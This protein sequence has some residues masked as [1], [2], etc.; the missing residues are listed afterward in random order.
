[1]G[2]F[3]W[4]FGRKRH[5]AQN[6]GGEP[7]GRHAAVPAGP[8]VA[9]MR[10]PVPQPQGRHAGRSGD[11]AFDVFL[12]NAQVAD[13]I[14]V[15]VE[16]IGGGEQLEIIEFGALLLRG[17]EVIHR[18]DV[19]I[20]P[21]AML[22]ASATLLTGITPEQLADAPD[23]G[24]VLPGIAEA[25]NGLAV[26]GHNVGYDVNALGLSCSRYGI[27][28]HVGALFDTLEMSR[29]LFPNA[30]SHTL[31]E[32]MR[33]VGI[34]RIEQHRAINDAEDTFECWMRMRAMDG[35]RYLSLGER[36]IHEEKSKA[37][38]TRKNAVFIKGMYLDDHDITPVNEKPDAA[39]EIVCLEEGVEINGEED[40]Q[41]LIGSYGY[42]AWL[43]VFVTENLIRKGKNEGYPTYWVY[44]D[45]VE[46]GHISKYQ[47]ERH[48]GQVPSEGAA[49]IAH[50]PDRAS[51]K[52][53]SIYQLR[54]QMPYRHEPVAL[55][56][57]KTH[58]EPVQKKA[59]KPE[60]S[61]VPRP[62]FREREE[63]D[64]RIPVA[65]VFINPKPHKK[66]LPRLGRSIVVEIDSELLQEY[67]N[68]S[69]LWFVARPADGGV[70]LRLSGRLIGVFIMG[71][72]NFSSFDGNVVAGRVQ[73]DDTGE[74]LEVF[75]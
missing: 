16:T 52:E 75:I 12:G 65:S 51:D 30:P 25:M 61:P 32:T 15:D 5:D 69:W 2:L 43:W 27:G 35:P 9:Q 44:L 19:F 50:V 22:P 60:A 63:I 7:R 1:M 48:C 3:S 74:H 6:A 68:G 14:V 21:N 26:I 10:A 39:A 20:R 17:Y 4:L 34:D 23:A 42:D 57:A 38:R 18:F 29:A 59:K 37:E 45:G 58:A 70:S 47:M 46:I 41:P 71:D 13:G 55:K 11:V 40:H 33:L 8:I 66:V 64:S 49:M 54:L 31:Q 53:R 72:I 28:L 56:C 62:V 73:R 24:Y 36:I 67:G